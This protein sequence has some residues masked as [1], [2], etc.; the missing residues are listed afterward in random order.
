MFIQYR[1]E[2]SLRPLPPWIL[3]QNDAALQY[4][5]ARS[6]ILQQLATMAIEQDDSTLDFAGES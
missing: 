4:Y 6:C 3:S 5:T 2:K 1:L